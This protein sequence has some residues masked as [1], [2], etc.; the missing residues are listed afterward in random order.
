MPTATLTS[1][2]QITLPAVLRA[3]LHLEPGDQLDFWEDDAGGLRVSPRVQHLDAL[4]GVLHGD[5]L[6]LSIEEMDGAIGEAATQ[7]YLS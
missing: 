3:R 1:K 7:E 6:P 5:A 4:F 2:G